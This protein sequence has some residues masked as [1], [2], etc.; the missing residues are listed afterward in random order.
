MPNSLVVSHSDCF[1]L[2]KTTVAH[3][4][5]NW[6]NL[7]DYMPEVVAEIFQQ[8][9]S[10][11]QRVGPLKVRPPFLFVERLTLAGLGS[12][13]L[14]CLHRGGR[15]GDLAFLLH[16]Q[17]HHHHGTSKHASLTCPANTT[18]CT[19][20]EQR[21]SDFALLEL[22][23]VPFGRVA[24][25]GKPPD[26]VQLG[27]DWDVFQVPNAKAVEGVKARQVTFIGPIQYPELGTVF[28]ARCAKR[29]AEHPR[30][31]GASRTA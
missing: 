4:H 19:Q 24:A 12:A 9:G 6:A 27:L 22:H 26:E 23:F 8:V 28:L 29:T 16:L 17:L 7:V 3:M 11:F 25:A 14:A 1:P 13:H 2:L 15:G 18:G 30:R 20:A 5:P 10:G 21:N 31:W